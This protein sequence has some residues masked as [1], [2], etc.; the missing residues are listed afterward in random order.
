VNQEVELAPVLRH[1]IED[2][3][4]AGKIGDVAV[5]GDMRPE[6][7][8]ERFDPLPERL[9]LIGQRQLGTLVGACLGDSPGDR[10]IVRHAEDQAPLAGHEAL[11]YRHLLSP[12]F[13]KMRVAIAQAIC[14]DKRS[15]GM[16]PAWARLA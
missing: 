2:G 10:A 8:G 11:T 1:R 5:A 3:I 16:L 12:Q 13:D 6:F 9:A 14:A 7:G 15:S 4:E